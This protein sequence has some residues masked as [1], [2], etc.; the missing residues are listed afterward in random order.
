MIAPN[1]FVCLIAAEET[2]LAQAH[3]AQYMDIL[4][5]SE[6]IGLIDYRGNPR[7][8]W[9]AFRWFAELPVERTVG[10]S[11]WWPHLPPATTLLP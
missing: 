6:Q 2:D 8:A 7:P 10:C 5:N 3:W 11:V 1:G 9:W 4:D